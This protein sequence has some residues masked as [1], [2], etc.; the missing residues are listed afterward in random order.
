MVN[1]ELYDRIMARCRAE[2]GPLGT[3]C[4]VWQGA[5]GN[6]GYGRTCVRGKNFDTHRA[7]YV[8]M[9]GDIQ[10]GMC[11]MHT[12]DVPACCN[13]KHLQLGT[14]KENMHDA[15]A[16]RRL[17]KHYVK[18]KPAHVL[19]IRR[20]HTQDKVSTIRLAALYGVTRMTISRIV[21]G[22][23]HAST[24]SQENE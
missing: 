13:V 15:A 23:T 11:V 7:I 3:P 20:M 22:I 17:G 2:L 4:M 21:R 19:E 5:C 6:S 18:M 10:K 8:A 12:C 24:L 1:Q 9:Y 14:H 16:K